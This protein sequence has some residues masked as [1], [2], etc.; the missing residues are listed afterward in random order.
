MMRK[1]GC[2]GILALLSLPVP[3]QKEGEAGQQAGHV[4]LKEVTVE[5]AKVIRK[6]DGQ[7]VVPSEAQRKAAA[8]GYSL[9][10]RVALPHIRVDETMHTVTALMNNGEVQLRLNGVPAGK[11]EM[12]S[13][14]PKQVKNIDFIDNPGVRYGEGI[15]YVIDIHTQRNTGGYTVGA[16][17]THTL[18]ARNSDDRVYAKFNRRNSE[19]S[20]SY[21]FSYQDFR[22]E[23]SSE[24][25]DYLL[26]DGSHHFVSREQTA[27][28]NRT[29]GNM[30]QVKYC[31]ADS[32]TYVFQATLSGDGSN[33]PGSFADF[34]LWDGTVT[35]TFRKTAV[36][37]SFSPALDLYFFHQLGKHQ[38]VTVDI[39]GTGIYTGRRTQNDEGGHYAYRADGRSWTVRSEA[40]YENRLKPFTLSAG[41]QHMAKYTRN[42]YEGD[43]SALNRIHL[44]ELYLF[45]EVKGRWKRMSCSAG[46]GVANK[47][48]SQAAFRYDYWTFRPK[49]TLGFEVAKGLDVR[50]TFQTYRRVSSYAMVSKARIRNNSR[51]WTVGNPDL[52]PSRVIQ[53]LVELSYCRPRLTNNV[54]MEYRNNQNCNMGVYERTAA[55]QFLYSQQNAG[56]IRMFYVQDYLK[57][58]L[59]P[60]HLSLT[61]A[62]GINRFFNVSSLY[63]HYLTSYTCGG[64]V[65]V[66]LGR[67]TLAGFADNGWK[68]VEGEQ[69]GH[70]SPAVYFTAGYRLGNCTVSLYLQHPFQ[71][72]PQ[73]YRSQVL[74][75]YLHKEISQRSRDLGNMLT[76][77]FNWRLSRGKTYKEIRKTIQQKED[78][79]T[80]IM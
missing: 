53:H 40:V 34:L 12:L 78:R 19:L 45:S 46:A 42:D 24:A 37:S 5:A 47:T 38:S 14:D 50:Y 51:E 71:Q 22:G 41:V 70:D 35:G 23:R 1:V 61:L 44:G 17:L 31:L 6:V 7:L 21:G 79:Q 66:Y 59:I 54:Y 15:A 69:L 8:D 72:H 3:A 2:M 80:G 57:Y 49:L 76:I 20:F 4:T 63:R 52:R 27:G 32:S 9:L 26:A 39:V 30:F 55:G 36:E 58:D 25:A 13:L 18:T 43:V 60:E 74:N 77:S 73:M 67:W 11:E 65:Q 68:F 10:G 16:D 56:S 75:E 28:R 33:S 29:L 64:N 48:Y 62:G